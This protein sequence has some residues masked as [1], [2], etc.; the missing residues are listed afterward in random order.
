LQN[1]RE[2]KQSGFIHPR[3]KEVVKEL[4]LY[5][6]RDGVDGFYLTLLQKE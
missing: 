4:Q 2:W 3:S 6:Q 5:P 1:H